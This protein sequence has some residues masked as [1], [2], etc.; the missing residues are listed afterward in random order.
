M[1][2]CEDRSHQLGTAEQESST[3]QLGQGPLLQALSGAQASAL[4]K[5]GQNHVT[6]KSFWL[7]EIRP[8]NCRVQLPQPYP[9]SCVHHRDSFLL[10]FPNK[11][12]LSALKF[13]CCQ[14]R[15]HDD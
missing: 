4:P 13:H 6:G 1:G 15:V 10:C 2:L 14:K 12:G 3:A 9:V 8:E 11:S 5:W 7:S